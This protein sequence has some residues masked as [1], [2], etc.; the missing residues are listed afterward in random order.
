MVRLTLFFQKMPKFNISRLT[1]DCIVRTVVSQLR[2]GGKIIEYER[3]T[4]GLG[5]ELK[6]FWVERDI[7]CDLE[8]I[9]GLSLF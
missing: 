6:Y 1:L 9:C 4:Q 5:F 8:V 7:I 2:M 3:G